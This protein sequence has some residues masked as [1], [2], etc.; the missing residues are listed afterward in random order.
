MRKEFRLLTTLFSRNLDVIKSAVA[1][2]L[3][4]HQNN[5]A[6]AVFALHAELERKPDAFLRSLKARIRAEH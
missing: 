3:G 1:G 6:D 4:Y 2:R 5:S